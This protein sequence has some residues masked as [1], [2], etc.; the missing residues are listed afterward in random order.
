MTNRSS[1]LQEQKQEQRQS[2]SYQQVQFVRLLE[3]PVEGLEERVR[4]EVLENPALELK[5]ETDMVSNMEDNNKE[6]DE[7]EDETE[8]RNDSFEEETYTNDVDE[9]ELAALGDYR[10]EDDIPDYALHDYPDKGSGTT[11]EIPFSATTSFYEILQEQLGEQ[12]FTP[13]QHE[14]AEYLI[15]SL[16]DDGLLRKELSNVCDE[17]S[18]YQNLTVSL[19][20][21]EEVLHA[22]QQ[23]DPAGIGAQDLREC[24]LLQLQRKP[25]ST[26]KQQALQILERCYNDFTYKRWDRIM[27][28]LRLSEEEFENAIHELTRL[29]PRP[30]SP[31]SE[32]VGKGMQQIIPDFIVQV[33]EEDK[34]TFYLNEG[35]VPDLRLSESF[36]R[37]IAEHS[38]TEN[39]S[40]ESR[41]AL[42]FLR[43]KMDA[44]QNFID[45]IEHRKRTMQL[46]MQTIIALQRTFFLEGDER[47]LKPML[48]KDVAEL[49]G[50]DISTVSRVSNSKYVETN[51]G[52]Y[53]LKFFFGDSYRRPAIGQDKGQAVTEA[54]EKISL[55]D[56]ETSLR[57]I[58]AIIQECIEHED[59]KH[60]LNDEELME[61]LK[62]KGFNL[63][64]RT[65][66]KYRQQM[67][68]PVARMRR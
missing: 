6:S 12:D 18:I 45:I 51:F 54:H 43:Q 62:L 2:L 55:D 42:L 35:N 40:R 25:E 37:L 7:T 27:Q 36:N 41:E 53:P 23:F 66:A 24:L 60:P 58:R 33:D 67:G 15:G 19:K 10:T 9:N 38:K 4:A 8:E 57:E 29:N 21:V 20:E 34:I 13:K 30:G 61:K 32:S 11:E 3:L 39:Q 31:L 28:H 26:V 48:M 1:Q 5:A 44:A 65:V 59:K 47:T 68:I 52:I 16:D 46:T 22:I 56:E 64:R 14:I 50:L 63:A 17:L 49:T